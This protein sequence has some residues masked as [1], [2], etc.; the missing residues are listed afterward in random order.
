MFSILPLLHRRIVFLVIGLFGVLNFGLWYYLGFS[1]PR[2]VT[3]SN[4]T[5][6]SATI[7]WTSS[8]I[9]SYTLY[10]STQPLF[11]RL[12]PITLPL[13]TKIKE[14]VKVINH[15]IDLKNLKNNTTYYLALGQNLHFYTQHVPDVKTRDLDL[16]TN[17]TLIQ[18]SV[19][20]PTL[21]MRVNPN[22]VIVVAENVAGDKYS[23]LTNSSGEFNLTMRVS[24]SDQIFFL[25]IVSGKRQKSQTLSLSNAK[26]R[27]FLT[28]P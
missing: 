13:V 5:K 14:P 3:A 1:L 12:L 22:P 17:T 4:I 28:L 7:T 11:L 20:D 2:F 10:V 18:G 9:S 6:N 21:A 8:K 19:Y 25:K 23:I 16:K 24:P 27:L 15:K 26:R